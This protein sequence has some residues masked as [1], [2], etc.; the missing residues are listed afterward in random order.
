MPRMMHFTNPLEY[1]Y[2]STS[3]FNVGKSDGFHAHAQYEIYYFH[4]GECTYIIGDRVYVL[5]PGDLVLMH[6][7]TLHRPHPIAGKRYERTTLHFDPSAVRSHLHPDRMDE[8]LQPF[9]ELGNCRINLKGE[10]RAEFEQLLLQLHQL[11]LHTGSFVQERLNVR[12][13]ELLYVI[14]DICQGNLEEH[15]PS[16][17]K[18]RHVQ[19]IIRY[20]DMHYMHDISLDD[21]ANELHLSKPYM[22]GLFKE[23]TGSTIFK[24]LYDRR[25]NQAK[26]LFQFQPGIS[27]TEAA[28]LSGF[29]RLSHF[30]R[31]FKQSVGCGPDLYR[32]RLHQ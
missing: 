27:V 8:V 13:C 14:A 23:T 32:T 5:A 30:S 22:A 4:A 15:R 28:R 25:I 26:V 12:L 6:G 16:S 1:S 19:H 7:M 3:L 21:L 17:D 29:K 10:V 31:I 9:E 2:R 24:Y 11:S 20:V 18:E